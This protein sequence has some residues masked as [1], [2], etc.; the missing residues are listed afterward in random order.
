[1]KVRV[2]W[3]GRAGSR[4]QESDVSEYCK[5]VSRRWPA[6]D[7]RLKAVAAGR[8]GDPKRALA[9]EAEALMRSV[10]AG[11]LLIALDEGGKKM[12]SEAFAES[13]VNHEE[14][15]VPG[16]VFAIG[17]DLGLDK[18][19][20]AQARSVLSLS[21]MTFAHQLARLVIWEQL[22][23][24]THIIGGGGYHRPGIQ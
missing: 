16:L 17:S 19:V 11:W 21:P 10:P 4:A 6:E 8:E 14:N 3:F 1:M 7:S 23:R 20:L 13:L 22:F 5:R 15:G 2:V 24:A 18:K 12:S 9:K